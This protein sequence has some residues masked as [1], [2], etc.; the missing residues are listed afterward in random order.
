MKAKNIAHSIKMGGAL[1]QEEKNELLGGQASFEVFEE[2]ESDSYS[3]KGGLYCS[4]K[5]G[6]YC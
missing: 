1:T 6:T 2:K 3:N 4:S 5:T